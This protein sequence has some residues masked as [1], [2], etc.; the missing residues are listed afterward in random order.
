MN[1]DIEFKKFFLLLHQKIK[2]S[3][4][5]PLYDGTD[6][7]L[8]YEKLCKEPFWQPTRLRA[9]LTDYGSAVPY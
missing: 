2:K 4:L 8:K 5:D 7:K 9:V 3:L 1:P 6:D